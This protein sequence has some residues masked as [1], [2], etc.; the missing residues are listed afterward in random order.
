M[1]DDWGDLLMTMLDSGARFLV[2]GAHALAV[3]GAPRATQD[4]DLWV[5]PTGDNPPRVW[6]ALVAFGAPLAELGIL[7]DDLSVPDTV[8]KSAFLPTVLICLRGL[9][10]IGLSKF[11]EF[12]RCFG[13]SLSRI[14]AK[15]LWALKGSNLRASDYESAA[16]PLS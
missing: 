11:R 10:V 12:S 8:C 3:H 14:R 9:P 7:P 4:L 15:S 5:D 1:A 16:L 13:N 2:V 6:R